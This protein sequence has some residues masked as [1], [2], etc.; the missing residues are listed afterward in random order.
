M[1]INSL[2]ILEKKLNFLIKFLLNNVHYQIK[3]VSSQKIY[4]FLLKN[5]IGQ[6]IIKIIN[7]LDPDKAHGHDVLSIR[8]L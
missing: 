5:V 6:N 4:D 1:I 3:I 2:L 7:N 8:M